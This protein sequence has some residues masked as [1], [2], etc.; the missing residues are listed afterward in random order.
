[1][2]AS[3]LRQCRGGLPAHQIAE[4]LPERDRPVGDSLGCYR[5]VW[6]YSASIEIIIDYIIL[7]YET[8][9]ARTRARVPVRLGVCVWQVADAVLAPSELPLRTSP[10]RA[11]GAAAAAVPQG[12]HPQ[13]THVDRQTGVRCRSTIARARV[14]GCG[15]SASQAHVIWVVALRSRHLLPRFPRPTPPPRPCYIIQCNIVYDII[16]YTKYTLPYSTITYVIRLSPTISDPA[17][18]PERLRQ[19]EHRVVLRLQLGLVQSLNR[20]RLL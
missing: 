1:M 9:S 2:F 10:C 16:Y 12:R 15:A 4:A 11:L 8:K 17:P 18:L 19:L 7:H 14:G 20:K 5:V 3:D 6:Y 13:V